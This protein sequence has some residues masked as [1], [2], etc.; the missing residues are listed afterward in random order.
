M[1]GSEYARERSEATNFTDRRIQ[2]TAAIMVK[3]QN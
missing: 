2:R 1:D 3:N